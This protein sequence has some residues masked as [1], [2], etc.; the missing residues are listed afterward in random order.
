MAEVRASQ[1]KVMTLIRGHGALEPLADKKGQRQTLRLAPQLRL[2][3]SQQP[4][5]KA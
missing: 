2:G 3:M 1:L 5:T 4:G